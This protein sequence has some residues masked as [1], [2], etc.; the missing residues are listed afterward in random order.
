MRPTVLRAV[1]RLVLCLCCLPAL[2]AAAQAGPED[3]AADALD[4]L[5][6]GLKSYEMASVEQALLDLDTVYDKVSAKTVKEI[7]KAVTKVFKTKPRPAR[8]QL[9]DTREELI[10]SYHLAIGLVFE[11]PEGAALLSAALKQRHLDDWPEMRAS[12]IEGLGYRRDPGLLKTFSKLLDEESPLVANA[13]A[14]ALAQLAEE[15][16][17]V[18]RSAARAVLDAWT[19]AAELAQRE[20]SRKKKTTAARE[21][22]DSIEGPF[23]LCLRKLTRQRHDGPEAWALW[24]KQQGGKGNW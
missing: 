12:L 17:A 14:G 13:A 16:I 7:G 19:E 23:E 11:R 20:Q 15:P 10:D 6:Q 1:A 21:R 18:R 5:K 9:E 8:E 4:A 2:V 24:F 3:L 22:L